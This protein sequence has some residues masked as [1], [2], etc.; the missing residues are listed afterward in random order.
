MSA[1][2]KKIIINVELDVVGRSVPVVVDAT[3]YDAEWEDGRV[4]YPASFDLHSA[5]W[6]AYEVSNELGNYYDE[7]IWEAYHMNME[8]D[9][10]TDAAAYED[11]Q[12][13]RY[14]TEE[15]AYC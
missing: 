11:Y 1:T 4:V 9:K 5:W 12:L 3:F 14:A 6:D 8:L 13:S 2:R 10:D 7:E 15:K